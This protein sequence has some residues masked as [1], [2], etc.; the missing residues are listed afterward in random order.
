MRSY[1][2]IKL[3]TESLEVSLQDSNIILNFRD[4]FRFLWAPASTLLL[5]L[6]LGFVLGN[7]LKKAKNGLMVKKCGFFK[8]GDTLTIIKSRKKNI[9]IVFIRP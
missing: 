5:Q 8:V 7:S 2:T 9:L 1:D 4:D 3:S 6:R